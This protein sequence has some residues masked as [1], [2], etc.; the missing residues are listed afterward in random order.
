[1]RNPWLDLDT[2]TPPFVL[3][4]DRAV[5]DEHNRRNAARPQYVFETTSMLPEPF[6]G[7]AGAPVVLLTGN[8]RF[9]DDDLETHRRS[10][11]RAHLGAMLHQ[12]P[13]GLPLVWLDPELKD[14]TGA[15]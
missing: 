9:R 1:M 3:D 8:P 5:V 4:A 12:K 7:R 6:L 15:S 10:D 13:I 11:V 2:T 14:T